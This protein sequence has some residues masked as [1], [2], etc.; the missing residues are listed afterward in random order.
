[1]NGLR[2]T[3]KIIMT[4]LVDSHCHLADLSLEGKAGSTLEQIIKR[5]RLCGVTH[6]LSVACTTEDF[7]RMYDTLYS[8]PNVYFACGVHPLNLEEDL[9]WTEDKLAKCLKN[10]RVIALGETGLDYHYAA[11][12]RTIQLDSFARQI[13]LSVSLKTPLIVHAREAAKDTVDLLRSENARD[14]GGVIHCF[15]DT[16]DMA[17]KCLDLGFYISFTGIATFKASDNVREVVRYVPL[18]RIMVETD[19]PYLAPIPVRGVEN[20]PAF[21]RYTLNFLADFKGVSQK[22]LA[23]VTSKN[24]E[25]LFGL[26]LMEP[27]QMSQID[28]SDYKIEKIKNTA[29]AD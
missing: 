6:F 8:F 2:T 12:T 25:N 5:A 23:E 17:R 7:A 24:F 3:T 21:V 1:M 28:V 11:E 13:A 20:E 26:N 22:R 27:P 10:D 15:T 18:D 29:F 14:C 4:F 19:C 9:N 16:V